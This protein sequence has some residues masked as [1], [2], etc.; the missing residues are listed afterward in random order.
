MRSLV[1]V[2]VVV[3]V[4]RCEVGGW[5][6]DL[7]HFCSILGGSQGFMFYFYLFFQ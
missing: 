1:V 7:H 2:V 3:V 6:D 5:I 4:V